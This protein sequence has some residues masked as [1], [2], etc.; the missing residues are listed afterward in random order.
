MSEI[1]LG[2]PGAPAASAA[3][4]TGALPGSFAL[5]ALWAQIRANFTWYLLRDS[6]MIFWALGIP[7][8]FL[9]VFSYA[10]GSGGTKQT[11]TFLV[12]G[13]IGAQVLSSGFFGIGAMLAEFRSKKLLR[14]VYLTPLP[15]WVFFAGLVLYRMSLLA[16]QALLLAGA[17]ALF[18]GVRFHGNPLAI[19][20]VLALGSATFVSLGAVIGALVRST[21]SANNLV[22]V[23]TVPLAFLSDAYFPISRFPA[24]LA[25]FLRLLPST[26]FIDT[27]RG[28]AM[29][30]VPLW[31]YTVWLIVLALWTVAGT[32]VSARFFRWV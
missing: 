17:G 29:Y 4:R 7:V 3:P 18:F 13:L 11:S 19:L 16:M 22:S 32:L 14:R 25:G 12:A 15:A 8:F 10:L 5:R 1:R 23:L 20:F 27:F 9:V 21:E 24:P 6:E 28:V 31:H 30:G 2:A 26:Q